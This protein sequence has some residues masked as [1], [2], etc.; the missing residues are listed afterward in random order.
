MSASVWIARCGLINAWPATS[1]AGVGIE[2]DILPAK[3]IVVALQDQPPVLTI[4]EYLDQ[5]LGNQS[6]YCLFSSV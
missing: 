4:M 1:Q 2:L 3:R 6:F 5:K